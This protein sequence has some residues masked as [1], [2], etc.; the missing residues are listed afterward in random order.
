MCLREYWYIQ[1]YVYIFACSIWEKGKEGGGGGG[2]GGGDKRDERNSYGLARSLSIICAHTS[3]TYIFLSL[4]LSL[5]HS[6]SIRLSIYLS[7]L[8][9]ICVCMY[10][11]LYIAGIIARTASR[12]LHANGYVIFKVIHS[13]KNIYHALN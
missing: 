3:R 5:S 4:S 8:P 9:P 2:G 12:I 6:L 1:Y 11:Q 10:P 7:T 13:K